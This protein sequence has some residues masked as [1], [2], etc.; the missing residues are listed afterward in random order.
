MNNCVFSYFTGS[1]RNRWVSNLFQ[2]VFYTE[3]YQS[4]PWPNIPFALCQSQTQALHRPF[5]NGRFRMSPPH[6]TLGSSHMGCQI[7]VEY[8]WEGKL[9]CCSAQGT[10]KAPAEGDP[11]QRSQ[12]QMVSLISNPRAVPVQGFWTWALAWP[13]R[14]Q[15]FMKL[16]MSS[17]NPTQRS[18]S[19]LLG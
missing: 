12:K 16:F 17:H 1:E 18:L 19:S 4:L 15:S 6:C 11:A 13:Q 7:V 3:R 14:R 5:T 2:P 8:Q 10:M 9:P